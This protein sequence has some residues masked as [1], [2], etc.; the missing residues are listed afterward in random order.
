MVDLALAVVAAVLVGAAT[1]VYL[2]LV[3]R[4]KQSDAVEAAVVEQPAA[5]APAPVRGG[6]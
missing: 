3:G 1:L 6:A 4:K 2:V 5:L